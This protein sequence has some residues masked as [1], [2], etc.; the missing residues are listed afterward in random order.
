MNVMTRCL[1]AGGILGMSGFGLL[2]VAQSSK[3]LGNDSNPSPSD[4]KSVD[5][6]FVAVD[7]TDRDGIR[8]LALAFN[9]TA[10]TFTFDSSQEINATSI[11]ISNGLFASTTAD[12]GGMILEREDGRDLLLAGFDG[13]GVQSFQFPSGLPIRENDTLRFILKDNASEFSTE[14][15]ITING[16]AP[17]SSSKMIVK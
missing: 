2:A 7:V 12:S 11:T 3:L 16:P 15:D 17:A 9:G 5:S 1:L 13:F 10:E 4:K 14:V 6:R 8:T